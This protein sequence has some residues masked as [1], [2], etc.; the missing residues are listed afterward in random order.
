MSQLR[1]A[2]GNVFSRCCL[3]EALCI[4]AA[5]PHVQSTTVVFSMLVEKTWELWP[6]AYFQ[7]GVLRE[8]SFEH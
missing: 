1:E 5:V 7:F 3:W 2:T 6:K 8:D 4:E